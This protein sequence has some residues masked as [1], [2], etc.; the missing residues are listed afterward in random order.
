ME[1]LLSTTKNIKNDYNVRST[2]KLRCKKVMMVTWKKRIIV[3]IKE[4][5]L[6]TQI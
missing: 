3:D 1:S 5:I 4:E 6:I 2:K